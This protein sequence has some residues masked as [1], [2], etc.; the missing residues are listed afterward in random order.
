MT[1]HCAV[2]QTQTLPSTAS[3]WLKE[4]YLATDKARRQVYL[5]MYLCPAC[6]PFVQGTLGPPRQ[7]LATRLPP[8]LALTGAGPAPR[9]RG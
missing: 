1:I 7:W 5:S 9:S 4:T 8:D 6:L 2:C 3:R